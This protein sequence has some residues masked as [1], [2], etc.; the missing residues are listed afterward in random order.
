MHLLNIDKI[1]ISFSTTQNPV[2]ASCFSLEK[3]LLNEKM[4]EKH[5]YISY[6][7]IS[8]RLGCQV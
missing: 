8:A 4:K 7:N 5:L 2:L 1:S 3:T 6:I